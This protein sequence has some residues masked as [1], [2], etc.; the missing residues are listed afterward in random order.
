MRKVVVASSNNETKKKIK[1]ALFNWL[2]DGEGFEIEGEDALHLV[3][4]IYALQDLYD[5]PY[6]D[7]FQRALEEGITIPEA[8][9]ELTAEYAAE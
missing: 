4:R 6:Q 9:D 1:L 5:F 3:N 7:V 8:V 2:V